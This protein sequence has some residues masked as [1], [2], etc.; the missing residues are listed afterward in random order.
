MPNSSQEKDKT[1]TTMMPT[2][3]KAATGVNE[4]HEQNAA[5]QESNNKEAKPRAAHALPRDQG[6]NAK[7]THAHKAIEC[8][9]ELDPER[10]Q[11][12][13]TS[14]QPSPRPGSMDFVHDSALPGHIQCLSPHEIRS[15]LLLWK[16]LFELEASHVS[17]GSARA[18]LH[19]ERHAFDL[20]Y[21]PHEEKKNRRSRFWPSWR[22][23]RH[24]CHNSPSS[25]VV[26]LSEAKA[27]KANPRARLSKV[28]IAFSGHVF[29]S[30]QFG[31]ASLPLR[32]SQKGAKKEA[33]G[34]PRTSFSEELWRGFLFRADVDVDST[35]LRFL[36]ARDWDLT[37]ATPMLTHAMEWRARNAI[38]DILRQGEAVVAYSIW[39]SSKFYFYKTDRSGRPVM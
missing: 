31:V 29:R 3:A 7:E 36:R 14:P 37:R 9:T 8:D 15:L 21:E 28:D 24:G 25:S 12:A 13:A 6:E 33:Y 32:L 34:I 26:N 10:M 2:R 17:A 4:L 20:Q 1:C 11:T 22:K 38:F 30:L 19:S 5:A 23:S 27:G 16:A 39:S 35:L 18:K